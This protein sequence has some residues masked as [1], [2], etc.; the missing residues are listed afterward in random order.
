MSKVTLPIGVTAPANNIYPYTFLMEITPALAEKWLESNTKNR[1]RSGTNIN[2]IVNQIKTDKWQV[3]GDTIKF[4]KKGKLADGQHRLW[5]IVLAEKPVKTYVCVGLPEEAFN[6][7]DLGKNRTASDVLAIEG[8]KNWVN[9]ASIANFIILWDKGRRKDAFRNKSKAVDH[10]DLLNWCRSH[11]EFGDFVNKVSTKYANSDKLLKPKMIGGLLWLMQKI[12]HDFA[13]SFWDSLMNGV[14]IGGDSSLRFIRK[15]LIQSKTDKEYSINQ[16]VLGAWIIK[17]FNQHLNANT[18]GK[19]LW[20]YSQKE[21][22][23]IIGMKEENR[24]S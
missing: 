22:Y 13:W 19:V 14:N 8:Y 11:Q 23:P 15:R 18:S 10:D 2:F 5:A 17:A 9:A 7:I 4:D 24:V 12:D 21:A 1:P 6:T 3:N 20:K 16:Y